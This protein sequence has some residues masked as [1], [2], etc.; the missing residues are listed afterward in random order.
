[1][2]SSDNSNSSRLSTGLRI[3]RAED[4]TA[5]LI[6]APVSTS[7]PREA[8]DMGPYVDEMMEL[9]TF[10]Q[11][12]R[13]QAPCAAALGDDLKRLL[14]G[15]KAAMAKAQA[16]LS[17]IHDMSPEAQKDLERA[18]NDLHS[19][20]VQVAE[21]ARA[22]QASATPGTDAGYLFSSIAERCA[23]AAAVAETMDGKL[24][25]PQEAVESPVRQIVGKGSEALAQACCGEDSTLD[26]MGST[27][28]DGK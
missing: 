15:G 28:T 14:E 4:D 9:F 27:P 12:M 21:K 23:R 6:A 16:G 26:L 11:E 2:T 8:V 3:N 20:T 24:R 5:P 22:C 10:I 17:A 25:P 18:V 7:G 1:M 19:L 13:V